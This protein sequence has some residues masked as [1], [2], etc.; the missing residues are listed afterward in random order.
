MSRAMTAR[1]AVDS[2]LARC[3][4]ATTVTRVRVVSPARPPFNADDTRRPRSVPV[5]SRIWMRATSS[6]ALLR[7]AMYAGRYINEPKTIGPKTVATTNH[8]VR[9]RSRYSRCTT[10][11]SFCNTTLKRLRSR[12]GVTSCLRNLRQGIDEGDAVGFTRTTVYPPF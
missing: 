10:A 9:T 7:V 1:V 6:D 12:Y 4:G 8:F 2:A 11:H 3:S 5:A